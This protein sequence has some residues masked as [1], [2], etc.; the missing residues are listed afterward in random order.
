M[1]MP[2]SFFNKM[3]TINNKLILVKK[4]LNIIIK[5]ESNQEEEKQIEE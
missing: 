5:D 2:I 4:S 3:R 1:K